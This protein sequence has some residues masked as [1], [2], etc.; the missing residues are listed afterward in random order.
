[1][2][3]YDQSYF[4][5]SLGYSMTEKE[6]LFLIPIIT[7]L[8]AALPLPQEA[9]SLVRVILCVSGA[10]L[11]YNLYSEKDGM[12]IVF[13]VVAIVFNPIVPLYLNSKVAWVVIDLIVAVLFSYRILYFKRLLVVLLDFCETALKVPDDVQ[14]VRDDHQFKQKHSNSFDAAFDKS[15]EG[16]QQ[17]Q[18]TK[19]AGLVRE[20]AD[21]IKDLEINQ[22]VELAVKAIVETL[23]MQFALG[24]FDRTAR[25][26]DDFVIGYVAGYCDAILQTRDIDNSSLEGMA[27]LV[28]TFGKLFEDSGSALVSAFLDNQHSPNELL[29][30]GLQAGGQDVFDWLN[31]KEQP[32]GLFRHLNRR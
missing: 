22:N 12:W 5:G 3:R 24:Q 11:A 20:M 28:I 10:A 16:N 4:T 9:Y 2:V 13:V 6:K 27:V 29:K 18:P 1:M 15:L 17:E 23:S 31:K 26:T 32:K 8:L 19:R 21:E 7:A 25:P 14:P 30:S